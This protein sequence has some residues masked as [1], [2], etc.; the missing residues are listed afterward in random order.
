MQRREPPDE[1][2]PDDPFAGERFIRVVG[3]RRRARV[4]ETADPR[5]RDRADA[6]SLRRAIEMKKG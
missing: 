3:K 1:G 5:D 4:G 2:L 6:A